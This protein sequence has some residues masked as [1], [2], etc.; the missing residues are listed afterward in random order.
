MY[1][2][3]STLLK[4]NKPLFA[5]PQAASTWCIE[6][7][8]S[9][10][11]AQKYASPGRRPATEASQH[12]MQQ[13]DIS[14]RIDG[15]CMAR[16]RKRLAQAQATGLNSPRDAGNIPMQASHQS[17]CTAVSISLRTEEKAR[18]SPCLHVPPPPPSTCQLFTVPH[19]LS[20]SALIARESMSHDPPQSGLC[21]G[22]TEC[23][24]LLAHGQCTPCRCAL[25]A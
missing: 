1:M 15:R 7:S 25:L 10:L 23:C 2:C 13:E 6:H 17:P 14:P 12:V 18:P 3:A 4:A 21:T 9:C 19:R 22:G 24:D 16:A 11:Q 8:P 20:G 5:E